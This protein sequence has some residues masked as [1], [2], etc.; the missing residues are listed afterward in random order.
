MLLLY[1]S[2]DLPETVWDTRQW[3]RGTTPG[4]NEGKVFGDKISPRWSTWFVALHLTFRD[5]VFWSSVGKTAVEIFRL[6]D[7][8]ERRALTFSIETCWNLVELLF[9]L[10]KIT[11]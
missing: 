3:F 4:W 2:M 5:D 8:G 9:F 10:L 11:S 6:D 7:F 1:E